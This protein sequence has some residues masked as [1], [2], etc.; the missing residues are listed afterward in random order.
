MS[1]EMF[2]ELNKD[3]IQG[4]LLRI[5][6][7]QGELQE[8]YDDFEDAF[9]AVNHVIWKFV[10]ICDIEGTLDEGFLVIDLSNNESFTAESYEEVSQII[11]NIC[12]NST[13]DKFG[14]EFN[15]LTFESIVLATIDDPDDYECIGQVLDDIG[16][17]FMVEEGRSIPE[18][19]VNSLFCICE[20]LECGRLSLKNSEIMVDGEVLNDEL[21]Y[22]NAKIAYFTEDVMKMSC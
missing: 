11:A 1:M 4:Y 7:T 17:D 12:N 20:E 9:N 16:G 3:S 18:S 5:G 6:Y 15:N 22:E 19:C 13:E 14:E 8:D 2:Q 21:E 10:V